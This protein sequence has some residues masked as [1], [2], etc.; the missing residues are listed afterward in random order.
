MDLWTSEG[1]RKTL[2][3]CAV[4]EAEGYGREPVDN[5]IRQNQAK[6][7]QK[8]GKRSEQGLGHTHSLK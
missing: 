6:T 3:G 7:R 1:C 4:I 2:D 8:E 5:K